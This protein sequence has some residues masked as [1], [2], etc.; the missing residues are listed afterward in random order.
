MLAL[1][2][3]ASVCPPQ[4]LQAAR[5]TPGE[6][7]TYRL[8]ALG[9][10]VGTFEVSVRPPPSSERRAALELAARAKTSA[11]ISTNVGRYE[12]YATALLTPDFAPL[13]YHE[14]LDE[15]ATHKATDVDFPP[16][17]GGALAAHAST[18]GNAEP[19]P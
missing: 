8:D 14:D 10:D 1:L 7:L 5:F 6:V 12:A 13:H 17:A 9:A 15:G 11:F 4:K 18:N 16:A 2:L 19:L 3:A